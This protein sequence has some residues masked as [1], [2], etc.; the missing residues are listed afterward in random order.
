MGT[1]AGS[2]ARTTQLANMVKFCDLVPLPDRRIDLHVF[3]L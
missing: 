3:A 1:I 2:I